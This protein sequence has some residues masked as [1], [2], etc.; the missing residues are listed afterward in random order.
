MAAPIAAN[1]ISVLIVDDHPPMRTG[2]CTMLNKT[3]DIFVCGEAGSGKEA[4]EL[5][6]RLH[7]K[8]ILLDLIMPDFSPFTFERWARENFPETITLVLTA[9]D[10]DVYLANM[11]QAGAVGY[12]G[13]STKADQLI[14]AIRKAVRGEILFDELQFMRAR[15]WDED[16]KRKWE[17]LTDHERHVLHQVGGGKNNKQIASN[18]SVNTKTVEKHL[19]NIYQKLGVTSRAETIVWWKEKGREIP[20]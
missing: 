12:L 4:E 6:E 3:P 16:V 5:L 18:L 17:S 15:G 20:T 11:M 19:T 8:I 1:R 2:L 13:K 9:H 7:P 10:R 14:D